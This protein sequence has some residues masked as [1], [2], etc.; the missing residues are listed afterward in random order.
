M[1]DV[2]KLDPIVGSVLRAVQQVRHVMLCRTRTEDVL[3]AFWCL[4]D[5]TYRLLACVVD[6]EVD[7][8]VLSRNSP[9]LVPTIVDALGQA[10][11]SAIV[12]I[13]AVHQACIAINQSLLQLQR[14]KYERKVR[15]GACNLSNLGA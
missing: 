11:K 2:D 3:Q 10:A 12:Q 13:A 7:Y 14:I 6:G 1:E 5:Q 9:N 15:P 4:Q 8:S